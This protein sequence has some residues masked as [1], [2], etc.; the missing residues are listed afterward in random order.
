[1]N[2]AA[3]WYIAITSE[4]LSSQSQ[5]IQLFG[6]SLVAWRNK[7]GKPVIMDDVSTYVTKEEYGYIWVWYGSV[8][9]L[10]NLP[11][12]DVTENNKHNYI[13]NYFSFTAKTSVQKIIE[14]VL[15]HHHIIR[16][17][18]SSFIDQ[19]EH[20]CL[21]EKNVEL[22]KLP[23]TKEAWF[24]TITET[25]IK[26]Y[27]GISEIAG[28]L[29]LKITNL[30]N[31]VDAWP[32]GFLSR[33]K[34]NGQHKI[35][36]FSSASPISENEIKW[37]VLIFVEKTN[38]FLLDPLYYLVVV[39]QKKASLLVDKSVRNLIDKYISQPSIEID[40]TVFNFRK[41]Y[42]TWVAKVKQN[43]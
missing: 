16:L 13:Y 38:N 8:N 23:I 36:I 11:V 32:S 43:R 18:N 30:T 12:F 27:F 9:P 21:D 22:S 29:G 20:T 4:E 15:N 7:I 31:R 10:F 1:M 17:H 34:I 26:G 42:E 5:R 6:R 24:G 25:Q 3:S 2:L 39:W 28:F 40:K 35:N 37:H 14:I 19:I 41:F 33:I